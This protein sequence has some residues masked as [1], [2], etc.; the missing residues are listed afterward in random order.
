M[1]LSHCG[2]WVLSMGL[3][4]Q[5][6][7]L[8]QCPVCAANAPTNPE[9]FAKFHPL[10]QEAARCA[11]PARRLCRALVASLMGMRSYAHVDFGLSRSRVRLIVEAIA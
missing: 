7:F 2:N 5:M 11:S 4:F 3:P 6:L 10:R 9:T 1:R 8:L